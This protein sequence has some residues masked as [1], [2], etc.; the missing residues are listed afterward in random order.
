MRHILTIGVLA[1]SVAAFAQGYNTRPGETVM[2][3]T[4]EGRG[5][6]YVKLHTKEA[7]K[8][9]AQVMGL[10]KN[11][12]YNGLRFHRAERTP[13]PFLLQTGDPNSK[14]G[15]L[16]DPKIGTGGSGKKVPY[17]DSGFPN[18]L[19]AVG[20]AAPAGQKDGGDSQFY[21]VIGPARFLDG[22]YTVFGKVVSGMDVVEKISRG[23]RVSSVS[24]IGG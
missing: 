19:G 20:L 10:A 1:A 17:E 24:I 7:P 4:I 6:V 18:E 8:A 13:K 16:D 22:N 23:D 11:G 5:D 21:I 2:R 3:L 14:A 12:F 15:S 9:T